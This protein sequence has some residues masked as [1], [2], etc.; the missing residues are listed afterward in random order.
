MR[1]ESQVTSVSWIPSAAITG[2]T[3]LP[4]EMGVTHYDDPPPE[5]I[6]DLDAIVSPDGARFANELRGWIDVEDGRVVGHGQSGAGRVSDTKMRVAGISMI[7]RA[8]AFPDLHPEPEVGDGYVR[9]FQTA[10]G[11]P[12]LQPPRRVKGAPF[13]WV[14]GPNVWTTL[15]LTIRADGSSRGELIGATTF[16]RHW[17]YD[18]TGKIA[19]KS[20]TIDFK[21]WYTTAYG[22]HSPWGDEEVVPRMSDSETSLERRL[23]KTVMGSD[24][25]SKPKRVKQGTMLISQNDEDDDLVLLLDGVVEICVDD[26]PIGVLGPGSILGERA[27]LE[28]GK[29]TASARTLT[30]CRV[31]RFAPGSVAIDDLVEL[32]EGH[33][34]ED[35]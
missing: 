20:A 30:D 24:A 29:R 12:G 23:S 14:Q 13:V 22:K 33:R 11:R 18:A 8:T 2:T 3:K 32:S 7:I 4:F 9:F 21:H 28:G 25:V 27:S 31:V 35:G 17:V 26:E 6:D 15:A 19:S 10:G 1:I 16:P 34:R 5:R